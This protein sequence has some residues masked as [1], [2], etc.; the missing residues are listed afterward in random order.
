MLLK[1][2]EELPLLYKRGSLCR[3]LSG[4]GYHPI[5]VEKRQFYRWGNVLETYTQ[6]TRRVAQDALCELL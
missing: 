4:G 2:L 3:S 5:G 6:K 1:A